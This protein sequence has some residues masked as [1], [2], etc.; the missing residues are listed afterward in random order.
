MRMSKNVGKLDIL[1]LAIGLGLFGISASLLFI[2]LINYCPPEYCPVS[3]GI[4][5][6]PSVF[7][8]FFN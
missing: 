6:F 7:L 8:S 5:Q 4:P 3:L 1:L 2:S